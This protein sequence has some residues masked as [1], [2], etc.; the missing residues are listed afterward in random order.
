MPSKRK[1]KKIE[2]LEKHRQQLRE[3]KMKRKERKR[4]SLPKKF[5]KR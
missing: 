5:K 2:G 4:A 1:K 3:K